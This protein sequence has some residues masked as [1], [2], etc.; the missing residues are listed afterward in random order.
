MPDTKYIIGSYKMLHKKCDQLKKKRFI[1]N[2]NIN[3]C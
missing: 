2:G 3:G 1:V